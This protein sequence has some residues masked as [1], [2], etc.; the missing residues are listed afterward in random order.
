MSTLSD[1]AMAA[2]SRGEHGDPFAVLGPHVVRRSRQ[3]AVAVRTF[4]P[5]AVRVTVIP[6]DVRGKPQ[7]MDRIHPEG[8]FEVLFPGRR[9]V[10]PYLLE[11]SW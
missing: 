6:T 3:S 8:I 7:V 4:L 9:T 11:V 1:E 10:F 5:R 2:I